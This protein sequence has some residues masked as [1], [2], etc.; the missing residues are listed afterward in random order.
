MSLQSGHACSRH[1]GLPH[2]FSVPHDLTLHPWAALA[3]LA[4]PR[5]AL[6]GNFGAGNSLSGPA[7]SRQPR[8][9]V[10]RPWACDHFSGNRFHR[11]HRGWATA[12]EI[13]MG[14][15]LLPNLAGIVLTNRPVMYTF[16]HYLFGNAARRRPDVR[17]TVGTGSHR[18][19]I[20]EFCP[21]LILRVCAR[22]RTA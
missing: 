22:A 16:D 10:P 14:R 15:K 7:W 18:A 5:A 19:Q 9:R 4:L 8:W 2:A 1:L 21:E 11:R 17:S 12:V 13:A 20:V 3:L 6:P